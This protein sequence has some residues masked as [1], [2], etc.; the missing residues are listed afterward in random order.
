LTL[1]FP[2]DGLKMTRQSHD[3]CS[4]RG[5]LPVRNVSIKDVLRGRSAVQN[6]KRWMYRGN[7]PN[8]L[9]HIL[10]KGWEV[11]HSSG[12]LPNFLAT[13]EVMGRKSG[14]IISLPVAIA[15]VNEQRYLVSMLGNEAQWVLN[16]RAAHGKAA[17]R[18]GRRT[19]VVLEEVPAAQRAP[20]LKAYLQRAPGARPHVPVNK[21]APL[22]EFA[23]IAADFPVFRIVPIK[24]E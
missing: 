10:N 16:V 19:E 18:S 17:I 3:I 7:R 23:A 5:V 21:N 20:I 1:I 11:V 13:L 24:P 9:A 2:F 15:I 12:I 6:I 14:K 22:E 4:S 8:W